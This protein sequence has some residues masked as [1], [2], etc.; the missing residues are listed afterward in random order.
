MRHAEL[1]VEHQM[2]VARK[3]VERLMK[4]VERDSA[5]LPRT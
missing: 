3:C 4:A 2:R 5:R 1:R